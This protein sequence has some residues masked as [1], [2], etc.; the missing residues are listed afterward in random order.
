MASPS[1]AFYC[2]SDVDCGTIQE[3][4]R[5]RR[6][7]IVL[8]RASLST[9]AAARAKEKAGRGIL[10]LA[11]GR[12]LLVSDDPETGQI[13]VYALGQQGLEVVLVS[14]AEE[15]LDRWGM[16]SF[17]L[18]IVDYHALQLDGV[19]VCRRLRAEAISP[20][21]LLTPSGNEAH[22]LEAYEA[23]VDECIAKPISPP[24]FLAKVRAW[25]RRSWTVP[26]E[27][28]DNLQ[29][30][31]FQLDP[32]RRELV[33]ATGAVIKLTNLELRLLQLLMSHPGQV[34]ESDLI[35]DRV[36][37]YTGG[38]DSVLLKNLVYRLR[39]KIE[40]EPSEPSYI[41]TVAGE[42]YTFHPS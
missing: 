42:G 25:L 3:R 39:R 20:I 30:G 5:Q 22:V 16:E 15:A 4:L 2:N 7:V 38:G 27:G 36:W 12:L 17:D 41:E 37:G 24:L 31:D 13:W 14:S 40:P 21:L 18:I 26:A 32:I 33:T 28:L 34:L 8:C 11:A 23:G 19:D 1:R 6:Q 9:T 29:A 10:K 35:V